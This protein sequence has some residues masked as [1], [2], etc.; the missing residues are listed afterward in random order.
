[1]KSMR[2]ALLSLPAISRARH[3]VFIGQKGIPAEFPGT[4]GVEFYVEER[5]RM[6]VAAGKTVTCYVRPW[7]ASGGT[8]TYKGIRLIRLPT[9]PTKHLDASVHS[10]LSTIHAVFSGADT[11]WY[12]AVGPGVFSIVPRVVGKTVI[13]TVHG[14]DWKR[15]KWNVAARAFLWF[16][17]VVASRC[18]HL[19]LVV[20]GDLK[21]YYRFKGI[22]AV[23]DEPQTPTI[24]KTPPDIITKKYGLMGSDYVLFMGRF[25]PEKRIEWLIGAWKRFRFPKPRLVLAGGS[26]RTDGYVRKL[27][28]LA[29][30]DP[31]IVFTGYVFGREKQELLANCRAFVLPSR[32]EGSP[33]VFRELPQE[34]PFLTSSAFRG[35]LRSRPNTTYFRHDSWNDFSD[36]F[37]QLLS[38]QKTIR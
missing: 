23:V 32:V 26:S 34:K 20:S 36:K 38:S 30:G 13:T 14:A 15:A 2:S 24:R 25:V 27:H 5:A 3:I 31:E 4:S 28:D 6:L 17:S 16:G 33:T 22:P 1:M 12:Q 37:R 19:L 18:S 35:V 29:S 21:E 9:I 10:F 8:G 11:V 7:A